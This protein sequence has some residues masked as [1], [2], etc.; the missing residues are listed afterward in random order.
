MVIAS[1]M[2]VAWLIARAAGLVALGLLT[3]SVTLGLAMSTKLL[4]SKRQKALFELHQALIWAALSMLVLHAGALVL[5]PVMHFGIL[6]VLVPGTAPWRPVAVAAGIVAGW[7]MLALALSFRVR[8]RIGQRRWR[9]FHYASF[10]AF[11]IAL[12]H[13]LT[14]GTEFKGAPGLVIAA[15]VIA[16]VLWLTFARI[17]IPRP[18]RRPTGRRSGA[19]SA[20]E[21]ALP[22]ATVESRRPATE[23]VAV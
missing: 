15:A 22:A 13:G 16:P 20:G 3:T 6:N 8:R 23:R 21:V 1:G 9:L 14:A 18:E 17:L 12:W 2:P 10:G 4:S 7:L 19:R 5:D 11:A